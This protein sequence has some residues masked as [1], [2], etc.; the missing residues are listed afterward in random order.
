MES[1]ELDLFPLGAVLFPCQMLPMKIFERRYLD[2][3]AACIAEK[4]SFGICLIESGHEVG[5]PAIPHKVG[6]E[7]RIVA[8]QEVKQDLLALVV[9][10]RRR[11]R[12]VRLLAEQPHIRAEV[13]WLDSEPV[14]FAGNLA[15]L[16][17]RIDQKLQKLPDD[18]R[19]QLELP[20]D[21]GGLFALATQLLRARPSERCQQLLELEG[22]L[23]W[24]GVSDALEGV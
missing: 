14:R 12:I 17:F 15:M 19:S 9:Q 21:P 22:E 16:R 6:C 7:A 10:G 1:E 23:I 4:R 18:V 13:Q 24:D 11:F 3:I 5:A 20:E 8:S 2:M